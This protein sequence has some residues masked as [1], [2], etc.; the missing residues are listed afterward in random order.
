MHDKQISAYIRTS[1]GLAV[2]TTMNREIIAI[3]VSVNIITWDTSVW[4]HLNKLACL[5]KHYE[6]AR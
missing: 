6:N 5:R 3:S 4:T 1:Y 2:Y